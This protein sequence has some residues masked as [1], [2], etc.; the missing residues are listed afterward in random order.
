MT[1]TR[2]RLIDTMKSLLWQRGYDAT[3]PNQVLEASG[4]GK[5]SLYH[6]F[7]SKKELAIAAMESRADE[8]IREVELIF[9]GKD[10]WLDKFERYLLMPR[11]GL[12]GC[13]LGR[14][15]HDPSITEDGQL[16]QPLKRYFEQLQV[17]MEKEFE[18]AKESGELVSGM[19]SEQLAVM[20]ISN[21]QGGFVMSRAHNDGGLI[22][23]ATQA[24]CDFL[25]S[26]SK[27]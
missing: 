25:T 17:I 19:S 16:Q 27:G 18:S 8:A 15:T 13:R 7:K 12:E 11:N 20:V 1:T 10:A 2:D 4:V 6:H 9:S 24:M 26:L 21:I 5:G 14:I 23:L 22:T 3:S